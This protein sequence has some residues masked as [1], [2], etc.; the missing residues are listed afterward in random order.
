[1]VPLLNTEGGNNGKSD[2]RASGTSQGAQPGANRG[3]EVRPSDF[4]DRV[5]ERFGG[6][7]ES[8]PTDPN[9]IGSFAPENGAGTASAMGKGREGIRANEGSDGLRSC[10]AHHVGVSPQE[11]RGGTAGAVGAGEGGKK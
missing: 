2:Q 6:I 8:K 5:A 11:D 1:M 7:P 9:R 10:K 3:G 4:R